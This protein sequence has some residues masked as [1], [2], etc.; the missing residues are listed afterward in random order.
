MIVDE[1]TSDDVRASAQSLYNMVIVGC[2]VIVGSLVAGRV[3]E[4]ATV[5]GKMEYQ[6][7]FGVPMYV[8]LGCLIALLLFYD[9]KAGKRAA[10]LK[11]R[12]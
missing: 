2:G 4:W 10:L 7:L 8:A 6:R 3:A 1:E 5:E 11:A 9:S 12:G